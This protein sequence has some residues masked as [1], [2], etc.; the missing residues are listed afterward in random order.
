MQTRITYALT[1]LHYINSTIL[2][3]TETRFLYDK[4]IF[5]TVASLLFIRDSL[6]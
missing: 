5:K 2:E 3:R 4:K 1:I 6:V